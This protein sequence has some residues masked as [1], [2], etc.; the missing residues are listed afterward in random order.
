MLAWLFARS[1]ERRFLI[2]VEDLDATMAFL[3]ERGGTFLADPLEDKDEKGGTYRSVEIATPL[4]DVAFRFV[5]RKGYA[6]DYGMTDTQWHRFINRYNIW[7]LSHFYADANAKTGSVG[8]FNPT[9]TPAG[10]NPLQ[11]RAS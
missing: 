11:R 5:E 6:R 3:E 4:G 9:T 10:A 2:R 8:C 1:T 7:K